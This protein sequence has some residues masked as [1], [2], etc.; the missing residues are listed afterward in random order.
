M[1]PPA[2]G[3]LFCSRRL[4]PKC[5]RVIRSSFNI[6]QSP[7]HAAR[8]H[9]A[10]S[11]RRAVS[12]CPSL[13]GCLKP[14]RPAWRLDRRYATCR[15]HAPTHSESQIHASLANHSC[16]ARQAG[17]A[18]AARHGGAC[19]PVGSQSGGGVKPAEDTHRDGR[20]QTCSLKTRRGG[21]W[22]RGEAARYSAQNTTSRTISLHFTCSSR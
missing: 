20:R 13:T 21:A 16:G 8:L 4:R 3:G 7:V 19:R 5:R 17:R 2:A 15:S 1:S 9:H 6:R 18:H 10:R 12:F 14:A 22:Q 11:R